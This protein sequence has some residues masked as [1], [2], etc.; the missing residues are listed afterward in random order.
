MA[1]LDHL[2]LIGFGEAGMT[3]ASQWDAPVRAY[4]IKT[5]DPATAAAK[6]DDYARHG[7]TGA[8]TL[9]EA[10]AGAELVLSVVTADQAL[11]AARAAAGSL[12]P[13]A[14]YCDLN[15][16]APGTK[17]EAAR[18]IEAAGGLYADVAVMA[19]VHPAR[20]AVPL[21]VSGPHADAAIAALGAV[22][23]SPTRVEGPVGRAST[24]KMLRSVMV[25]G[26]EAL[27]AECFLAAHEAGVVDEVAASLAKSWP[28]VD[29]LA[30]ADYNLERMLVHGRRRAA[31]MDE[32]AK[33]VADLTLDNAMTRACADKQRA[34][35]TLG[36]AAP[37]GLAAKSELIL[38]KG[39][40]AA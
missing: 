39:A 16:V 26:M 24:I 14:L 36:L 28:G 21:L 19:P 10:L 27:S 30:Q 31:E 2:A 7:A 22:G 34:L 25:K 38:G 23:F 20:L 33:T 17:R 1:R 15:S 32:V 37:E 11:L 6:S 12:A 18:A 40:K 4:D 35:G 3:F 8:A 29:W 13:G 5:D 9:A